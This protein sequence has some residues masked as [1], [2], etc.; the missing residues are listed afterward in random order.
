MKAL[1]EE[2]ISTLGNMPGVDKEAVEAF[3]RDIKPTQHVG[4]LRIK[5]QEAGKRN[6]SL[7]TSAMRE[8]VRLATLDHDSSQTTATDDGK[9]RGKK[10][11]E[12]WT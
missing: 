7:T 5:L 1:T 12:T 2:Q 11:R 9:E 4:I 3:L 6:S 10:K 8:G